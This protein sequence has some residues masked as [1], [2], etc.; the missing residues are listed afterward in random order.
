MPSF[1]VLPF[2]IGRG[3]CCPQSVDHAALGGNAKLA[4]N[5]V[6]GELSGALNKD[7]LDIAV[8][9]LERCHKSQIK[10]P[11][12]MEKMVRTWLPSPPARVRFISAACIFI[13]PNTSAS[14][15]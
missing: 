9:L 5:W 4:A 11:R 6:M 8:K 13:F 1:R 3:T 7:N 10:D 12:M 14:A 15:A 2:G